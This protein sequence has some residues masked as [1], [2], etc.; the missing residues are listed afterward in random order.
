MRPHVQIEIN[1]GEANSNA[2]K[3]KEIDLPKQ[4]TDLSV[5]K[6]QL[7]RHTRVIT[8]E[9]GEIYHKSR[10]VWNG[11]VDKKPLYIVKV[12]GVA[13]VI[14][15]VKWAV[16]NDIP[17]S[18]R[19]GGHSGAGL[20]VVNDGL[21]IDMS[22]MKGVRVDLQKNTARAESGVLLGEFDHETLAFGLA[23]T[24]GSVS[25]TGLIGM[26]LGGGVGWLARK[27]GLTIDNVLTFDIVLADGSFLTVSKQSHPDLFW[28]LR[29]AG[30]NFGVVTSIEYQL[31][32]VDCVLSGAL[33]YNVEDA[34]EMLRFVLKFNETAPADLTVY[35]HLLTKSENKK[36]L[37]VMFS[38]IGKKEDGEK[39]I[40]PLVE[41]GK[42]FLTNIKYIPYEELQK[43]G[44]GLSPPFR[45]YFVKTGCVHQFCDEIIDILLDA[46]KEVPS[47]LSW[48]SI[49]QLGGKIKEV[50]PTDSAY[51]MRPAEYSIEI[52]SSWTE[53]DPYI[54][55][56]NIQW[57]M[58]LFDQLQGWLIGVY[59]NFMGV[60]EVG[61]SS[62]Q[63][64][65]V[66]QAF[67]VNL[68]RLKTIKQKYDPHNVFRCNINITPSGK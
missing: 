54:R 65:P 5:L 43:S 33:F 12:S 29:G 52:M 36:I 17:L 15:C 37:A 51:P 45:K 34:A 44:D 26:T 62:E 1:G 53:E 27:Y 6:S 31:Y 68:N 61:T 11:L 47:S 21:V 38:Y 19:S 58:N 24:A 55:D 67:G 28:A 3:I 46:Y 57:T 60:D 18:V 50:D 42:P 63:S 4:Q 30:P 14:R 20:S 25:H 13:D 23:T 39:L 41:H 56:I 49:T 10:R 59:S 40:K 64:N 66:K 16:S 22:P 9:D 2:L 32:P 48:I 8:K 35:C 7:R